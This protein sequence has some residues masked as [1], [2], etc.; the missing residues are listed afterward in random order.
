[1]GLQLRD[2]LCA[3][4]ALLND[5]RLFFEFYCVLGGFLRIKGLLTLIGLR[6]SLL[7]IRGTVFVEALIQG[8]IDS[9]ISWVGTFGDLASTHHFLLLLL[10]CFSDLVKIDLRSL[11]VFLSLDSPLCDFLDLLIG[12]VDKLQ[13]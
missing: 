12:L 6:L 3:I 5:L 11:R 1:M 8:L 13:H 7:V 9:I 2:S 4:S 10:N